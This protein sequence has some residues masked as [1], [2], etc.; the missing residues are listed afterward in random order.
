M[1]VMMKNKKGNPSIEREA[2]GSCLPGQCS[3]G[4]E[5]SVGCFGFWATVLAVPSAW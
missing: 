2:R 4:L 3:E 1:G 5:K